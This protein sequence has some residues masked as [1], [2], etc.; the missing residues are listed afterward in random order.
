M[1]EWKGRCIPSICCKKIEMKKQLFG[2]FLCL[3]GV[4]SGAFSAE[5]TIQPTGGDDAALIQDALDGLVPDDTLRLV[6]DFILGK[7]IYL[8]SDFTWILEGTL[9]LSKD[10]VLDD[11]GWV[12]EGVDATR[13][14]GITE[15]TGGADN[16]EMFGG[17]YYGN[18]GNYATSMRFINFISVTNSRFHDMII[19]EATDDN[20]TLGPGSRYNECRNLVGSFAGGNALTDKGEY[21]K[22]YDCIAEDCASDGWTPKCRYSEFYRC[23]GRRN[24]GPGFGMYARLDGS[25]NPVD[26]GDTIVGNSFYACESYDNLRGG[27]SFNVSSNCN[28]ALIKDNYIQALVYN[29]KMQGVFFRNKR[30]DGL[31]ENN[32]V[33]LVAFGNLGQKN[34]GTPSI[35]GGGLGTEGSSDQPVRG[36]TGKVICFTN[37]EWDVNTDKATDC[38]ITVYNPDSQDSAVL[39]KGDESN[40][41]TEVGFSC[42][43]PLEE[44]CQQTY[45]AYITPLLPHPPADFSATVVSSSQIDLSWTDTVSNEDG[46]IIEYKTSGEYSK[47]GSTGADTSSFICD[48]LAENTAYTFRVRAFNEAGYSQYTEEVSVTTE[49]ES[50]AAIRSFT[51]PGEIPLTCSPNPFSGSAY[52]DYYL[53]EDGFVTLDIFDMSG[54]KRATPVSEFKHAGRHRSTVNAS[55]LD[56][57]VCYCRMQTPNSTYTVKLVPLN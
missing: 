19:T 33:E 40:V 54:K 41:L 25:G 36:I 20:F 56:Y 6:G 50:T 15:K 35:Y 17:T 5:I 49:S 1:D 52:I 26:I 27:F 2:V 21:N 30:T 57:S 32:V 47:I 24:A 51:G 23:I 18:A 7:T 48:E 39:K 53:S 8:P 10:A 11:I 28:G 43:D 16:I 34:D 13:R 22:W 38:I 14:T 31:V 46:F 9:T 37:L 45:C 3:M 4:S 55:E 44:W 12:E 29:N 42:S